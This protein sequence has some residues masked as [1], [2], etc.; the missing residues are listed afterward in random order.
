MLSDL[1]LIGWLWSGW[2]LY[3]LLSALRNKATQR[4]ESPASR[5]RSGPGY[6]SVATGVAR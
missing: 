3:W 2:G 1:R 5:L 4:R 6:T